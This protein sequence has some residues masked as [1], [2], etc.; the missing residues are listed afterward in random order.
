MVV[1]FTSKFLV[2]LRDLTGVHRLGLGRCNLI[3]S[4]ESSDLIIDQSYLLEVCG[5]QVKL[6]NRVLLLLGL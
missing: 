2:Y 6:I 1:K 5:V 3:R 4:E